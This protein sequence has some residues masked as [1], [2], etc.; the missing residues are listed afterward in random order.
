MA[1]LL[2]TLLRPDHEDD[3]DRAEVVKAANILQIGEFQ[4]L[5]LAYEDWHGTEIPRDRVDAYFRRFVMGG[6]TP[7]WVRQYARRIVDWDERGLLDG[8]NPDYHRYDNDYYTVMPQGVRRFAIA[9]ACVAF[10]IGGGVLVSHYSTR[11]GTS[12]LPPYFEQDEL[13]A[14]KPPGP[15]APDLRGS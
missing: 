8:N 7:I 2:E 5:Q 4:L 15:P 1:G 9:V 6:E 12:V 13:P 3:P 11:H 14:A 10:A